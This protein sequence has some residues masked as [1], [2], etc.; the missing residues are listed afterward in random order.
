VR[1][2]NESDRPGAVI[3]SKGET[4][5]TPVIG[6]AEEASTTEYLLDAANAVANGMILMA[7]Y[8]YQATIIDNI[9]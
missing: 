4:F 1:T 3:R 9:G 7:D 5:S 2:T 6:G 8:S